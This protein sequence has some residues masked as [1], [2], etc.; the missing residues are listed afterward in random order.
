MLISP[1]N[2]EPAEI[3]TARRLGDAF[4]LGAAE[5]DLAG[6]FPTGH[7]AA[8]RDAGL[9]ALTAPE[10]FGGQ[11]AGLG[12][13]ASIIREIGRGDPAVALI[14][15]MQYAHLATLHRGRWSEALVTRVVR[16]AAKEGALI[17]ALRVEP[18]LGTPMRG[19][20]PETVARQAG[21]GWLLTGRKIYSTGSEGLRWGVVWARTD[22]DEPRVGQFLV[23]MDA[24]GV[25][26]I[27]GW[28]TLGLRASSSHDVEF[29]DVYLP[30]D[31]AADIRRPS[32]WAIRADEAIAWSSLL[33]AA[34]YTGVAEAGRDWIVAFLKS[35]VPANLGKPLAELPRMQEAVGGIE[36]HIAVN[37]RLIASAAAETDAGQAPA[38][39]EVGIIK[40]VA[41]EN[42]IAAVEAALKLAGNHGISRKNPLERHYR[43]V[44]CGR[45]HTP[46]EDSVLL[47]AGRTALGT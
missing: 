5:D 22:E 10:Q 6:R 30:A 20:L 13:A 34:L 35:R 44:L 14:L 7:V 32:E 11:G 26:I 3:E 19:G 12:L 28:D 31:H 33:I 46:Q 2:A 42:A 21:D 15:V 17:N 37:R 47:A 18:A 25:R 38:A 9:L 4:A 16:A 39:R 40:H 23:P 1:F 41:T 45:I 8:L 36:E 27:P 29:Q 24:E 43:D